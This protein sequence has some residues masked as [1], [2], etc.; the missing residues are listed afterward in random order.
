MKYGLST[1]Q[2]KN[3]IPENLVEA[4]SQNFVENLIPPLIE[5]HLGLV[6]KKKT[7]FVGS[8]CLH[9]AIRFIQYSMRLPILMGQYI[10]PYVEN[11]LFETAVPII[12]VSTHDAYLF[13]EDPIE[14]LRKLEHVGDTLFST[15]ASMIDLVAAICQHKRFKTD[16]VPVYLHKFLDFCV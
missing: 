13:K 12:L 6:F 7:H 5:S 9:Y 11:I 10:E 3:G 4:F 8:Q 1:K 14:F 15:K 16:T 2:V